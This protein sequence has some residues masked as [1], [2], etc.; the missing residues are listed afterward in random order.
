MRPTKCEDLLHVANLTI[1]CQARS[2]REKDPLEEGA[3]LV[4]DGEVEDGVWFGG[5]YPRGID[6][7]QGFQYEV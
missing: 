2:T 3:I 1:R 7:V 4:V 5:P 6:L